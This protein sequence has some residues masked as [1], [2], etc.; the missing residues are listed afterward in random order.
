MNVK[1]DENLG[2][3]GAARLRA[4]GHDV[5]TVADEALGGASDRQIMA[6]CQRERRVLV[7]LDLDFANPLAFRPS[8]SA[9]IAVLRPLPQPTLDDLHALIDSLIAE[10]VALP[11][12]GRLWIV[13][14]GRIRQ[15]EPEA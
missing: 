6:V 11:I 1:L 5:A 2:L 12:E 13:E 10:L 15:Y 7:T 3:R 4:A 8:A 9:G 14:P